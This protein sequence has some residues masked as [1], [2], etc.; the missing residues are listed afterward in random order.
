MTLIDPLHLMTL[1]GT[2]PDRSN[3]ALAGTSQ[4][5]GGFQRQIQNAM[6]QSD[7]DVLE[8]LQG[9]G[10]ENTLMRD[11]L[12]G[13]SSLVSL[14]SKIS[15]KASRSQQ[16]AHQGVGS[17]SARFESGTQGVN[18]IGYDRTGGTSYGTYQIA[19]KPGTMGRFIEYLE[20]REPSWA[21]KL[22]AAGPANTGSR[23]GRMPEAWAAI[24]K[25]DPDRFGQI[26]REFVDATH[27][28]PARQKILAKTGVDMDT[29]PKAAQEALWSTSVQHGPAGAAGIFG[30]IISSIKGT[31]S[32]T[33]F[34]QQLINNV[35][36]DRKEHFGSS[37]A[38][39]QASVRGRMN[40]EK[41]MV[42]AMLGER[43]RQTA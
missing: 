30:R 13:L 27:Y 36:D 8:N 33:A 3:R 14:R 19:S 5:A 2:A 31:H 21:A 41:E 43:D 35:Y 38:S 40:A 11:A 42:L 39:V 22:K 4:K 23:K 28:E 1:M 6:S 34:A 32:G 24:A 7:R 26:Q 9:S 20:E 25:E 18:A 16:S 37:T 15:S 29:L 12:N 17:L 10:M